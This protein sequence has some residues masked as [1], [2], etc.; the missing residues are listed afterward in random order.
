MAK[1]SKTTKTTAANVPA[2]VDTII[3][4]S[5]EATTETVKTDTIRA[6]IGQEIVATGQQTTP[7]P[8]VD[9][10]LPREGMEDQLTCIE[11]SG[12]WNR[13]G[14]IVPEIKLRDA[15]CILSR[16]EYVSSPLLLP[17]GKASKYAALTCSDNGLEVGKPFNPATYGLLNNDGFL[18][19]IESILAGLDK[20]GLKYLVAT[21]GTVQERERQFITIK[22]IG[23]DDKTKLVIGGREFKQ[24]LNCLNSIPSNSGCTITFANQSFCVCCRNTFAHA[25]HGENG[26]KFHVAIK[27][28]KGMKASLGDVPKLVEAYFTGNVE[29]FKQLKAFS[30]FPVSIA[31]A[32]KFFTAFLNRDAKGSL[33]DKTEVTTRSSNMSAMLQNL[34]AGV[35]GSKTNMGRDALDLF[36]AV[37]EYYTH[38]SAG[39]S[40]DKTKQFESSE[41]GNGL[42][43]KNE[44]F[45]WLIKAT[46]EP[47]HWQAIARV[48][49]TLLVNWRK[50]DKN[51]AR[52]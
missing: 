38:F 3:D 25:L 2:I 17:N 35:T 42:A 40:D 24:F 23:E 51:K 13:H 10:L 34:F 49:D 30:V 39:E 5:R 9:T 41:F 11:E 32:E 52:R 48:G 1:K 36:S 28:T 15:S 4:G 20:L 12:A 16:F 8:I 50:S 37:T 33:T 44:F 29:L 14:N 27:H 6:Q 46:Q 26:G 21:S 7:T 47:A 45:Q 31:D 19:V 22:I 18:S 43:N